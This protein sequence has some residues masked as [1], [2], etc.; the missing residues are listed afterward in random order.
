MGDEEG[1]ENEIN[2]I[3]KRR[4][5]EEEKEDKDDDD[6]DI[7]ENGDEKKEKDDSDESGDD[8]KEKDEA[9]KKT[10]LLLERAGPIAS[11]C[12]DVW[13]DPNK[14]KLHVLLDFFKHGFDG[15]GDDGGSCIDGRL[16]S[17]WN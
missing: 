3:Q 5:N 6:D 11:Y 15:D 16:T 14:L 7:D 17:A 4:G 1:E 2:T 10:K 8:E 12:H 9:R 13:T